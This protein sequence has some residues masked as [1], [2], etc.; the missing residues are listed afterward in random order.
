[1]S[2]WQIILNYI[3]A[4]KWPIVV[5]AALFYFR[6]PLLAILRNISE[7]EKGSIRGPGGARI[8]WERRLEVAAAGVKVA[9]ADI[10]VEDKIETADE[11]KAEIESQDQ[12]QLVYDLAGNNPSEAIQFAWVLIE[13]ALRD[14]LKRFGKTPRDDVSDAKSLVSIKLPL[15][16]IQSIHEM[17][18]LQQYA[19]AGDYV[20]DVGQAIGYAGVAKEAVAAI[21]RAPGPEDEPQK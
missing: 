4:L 16:L 9:V 13:S 17:D 10:R 2:T 21:E 7:S 12:W 20:P 6:G 15:K 3:N 8:D 19:A 1:L 11:A 5:A 14:R 18:T